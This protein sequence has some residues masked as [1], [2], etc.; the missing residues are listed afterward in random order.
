MPQTVQKKIRIGIYSFEMGKPVDTVI[1][2]FHSFFLSFGFDFCSDGR[3]S[4]VSRTATSPMGSTAKSSSKLLLAPQFSLG[5]FQRLRKGRHGESPKF[6]NNEQAMMISM[7]ELVDIP[8]IG[9][10]DA[11]PSSIRSDHTTYSMDSSVL[12]PRLSG[13]YESNIL[14]VCPYIPDISLVTYSCKIYVN[15]I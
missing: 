13:I 4:T 11:S 3:E 14:L 8:G 10:S 15:I 6:A 5:T 9:T 1:R 2:R 12:S 7:P